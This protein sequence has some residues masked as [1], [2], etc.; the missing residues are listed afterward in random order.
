MSLITAGSLAKRYGA[1]DIF[2]NLSFSLARGTRVG[3][4]GD[5]GV[6]KTTLLRLLTGTE[7]PSEGSFFLASGATLGYLPQEAPVADGRTLPDFVHDG[8]GEVSELRRQL[9]QL[10]QQMARSEGENLWNRYLR[11]QERFEALGGYE[12][13][14]K[15][16]RTLR[17]L[18]FEEADWTRPV[19]QLS[20]GQR[21][22]AYLARLLLREPDVLLLDEPT[23][24]LDMGAMAWLESIL[25]AWKGAVLAVS[26]D[27]YFLDAIAT[28][29]WE[30]TGE[31]LRQYAGNYS[32][33]RSQRALALKTQGR[34]W[35][36]QKKELRRE[37]EFL[38]RFSG[39][40]GWRV[41]EV[42][43]REK[44]LDDLERVGRPRPGRRLSLKFQGRSYGN[45]YVVEADRLTVG[46][47][48]EAPL[49]TA[50]RLE[51]VGGERLA[52]VG[53]N[54]CGKTT[55]LRT[56]AGEMSP[57]GGGLYVNPGARMGYLSQVPT[58]LQPG[59]TV[60]EEM[61]SVGFAK[62][63]EARAH[64]ARFLFTGDDVFKAVGQ[65][66]GGERK[67]LVLAK[68]TLSE[69]NLLLLDEPT[70]HLDTAAREALEEALLQYDGT[71]ILVS[72]D[73]YL[74][75]RL[76]TKLWVIEGGKAEEVKGNYRA[77]EA[78]RLGTSPAQLRPGAPTPR[79]PTPGRVA[80]A[81][82]PDT[83]ALEQE[84]A[85][86]ERE[87]VEVEEKLV[88]ASTTA[89]GAG[90]AA[91]ERWGQEHKR[92]SREIEKAYYRWQRAGEQ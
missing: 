66:S 18:G 74:I 28:H 56:I 9:R 80:S 90:T 79:R 2:S 3:L 86:L 45:S 4:V 49:F 88:Y 41:G 51:L 55:L 59:L 39:G 6:G 46:F 76:A 24:H 68:M 57:L 84:I 48:P 91:L 60:L 53:A 78:R 10:E 1:H 20:G 58:E 42:H 15:V 8:L 33:Y 40:G 23:N 11:L 14:W 52:I 37:E 7:A 63:Q 12:L 50:E 29:I 75:N 36:E 21:T 54:G 72:H 35:H 89:G 81:K 87:L 17:G 26:H 69:A 85:A 65:L 31:G 43:R 71:I 61:M 92:L 27:R 70:N 19:S 5:N 25:A 64:L 13:D 82:A 67:R 77:F 34:Q 38:R 83:T 30:M 73:R 44:A 16:E 47:S 62:A 32:A 22:R